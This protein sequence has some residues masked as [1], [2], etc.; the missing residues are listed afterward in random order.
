VPAITFDRV[1][2]RYHGGFE[3]LHEVSFSIEEDEFA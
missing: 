2:R 1:T 3:A